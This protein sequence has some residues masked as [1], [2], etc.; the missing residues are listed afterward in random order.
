MSWSVANVPP[1]IWGD[2]VELFRL[3][4][5]EVET[6]VRTGS[7]LICNGFPLFFLQQHGW[8]LCELSKQTIQRL[9]QSS[10]LRLQIYEKT[11]SM[12]DCWTTQD[13]SFDIK[14]IARKFSPECLKPIETI[15]AYTL[16]LGTCCKYDEMFHLWDWF[17]LGY[18]L[19]LM[20]H[21]QPNTFRSS[22]MHYPK[23]RF[24]ENCVGTLM[25]SKLIS[26]TDLHQAVWNIARMFCRA[27]CDLFETEEPL[28][29]PKKR[30][31]HEQLPLLVDQHTICSSL[32]KVHAAHD[33]SFEWLTCAIIHLALHPNKIVL[34]EWNKLLTLSSELM[35]GVQGNLHKHT[36]PHATTQIS[37]IQLVP[38]NPSFG[39]IPRFSQETQQKLFYDLFEPYIHAIQMVFD[40]I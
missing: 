40:K 6:P 30:V 29:S 25:F 38:N 13:H 17:N 14:S 3:L 11:V 9:Q 2:S 24:Y 27:Y 23:H 18:Q 5:A 12:F 7:T 31:R 28:E 22:S 21:R 15:R 33:N 1:G 10:N 35:H 34:A 4:T 20:H 37:L 39:Y 36:L 19:C 26:K 32:K 8:E 16:Y